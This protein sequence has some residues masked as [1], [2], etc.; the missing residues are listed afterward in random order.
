MWMIAG[1]VGLLFGYALAA[2]KAS[3]IEILGPGSIDWGAGAFL[4]SGA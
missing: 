3:Y 2:E 4:S 1:A